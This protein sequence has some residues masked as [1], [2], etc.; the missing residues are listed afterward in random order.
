MV[1]VDADD[2]E[3]EQHAGEHD[4]EQRDAVDAEVPR[5]APRRDPRVLADELEAGVAGVERDEQPDAERGGD[6]A[7]EQRDELDQ[8]G[9]ALGR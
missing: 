1:R 4:E 6:H 9:A 8:L 2:D 7:G 3:R 5:D